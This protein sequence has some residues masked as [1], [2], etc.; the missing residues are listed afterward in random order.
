MKIL[1]FAVLWLSSISSY[2]QVYKYKAFNT[3][4]KYF[5]ENGNAIKISD[6]ISVDFLVVMNFEKSRINTYGKQ[7]GNM[8]LIKCL[9]DTVDEEGN[10]SRIY[11]G[12]DQS[13]EKCQVQMKFY[14]GLHESDCILF[15]YYA[16]PGVAMV[17]K[18]KKDN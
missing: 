9:E 13:G 8:D 4:F 18:L 1:I 3:Y 2:S 15:Y 11:T 5:D 6:S 14:K 7:E 17:Y 12:V 16:T 10:I